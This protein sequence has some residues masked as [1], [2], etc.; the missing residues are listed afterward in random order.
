MKQPIELKKVSL[1]L[2]KDFALGPYPPVGFVHLWDAE[3]GNGDYYGL[4]WPLGKENEEPVVCDMLHDEWRLELSFSSLSKFI[5]W[6][7]ANNWER[8]DIEI[9]DSK[10]ASNLYERAKLLYSGSDVNLAINLL[11]E[12]CNNFPEIS[13]Y[14]FSLSSQYRRIGNHEEAAKAALKAFNSNWIFGFPNQGVLRTLKSM[15]SQTSIK[16][17]PLIQRIDEIDFDFGGTKENPVYSILD[18]C[19][20]EYFKKELYTDGL[21]MFQNY[22]YMMTSETISFQERNGFN[23]SEWQLKFSD[24]CLEYLGD[25]RLFEYK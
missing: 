15:R 18:G 19:I 16:D 2:S 9:K 5:E 7:D 4:Y 8:G 6:L 12:A 11:S 24:L 21:M 10:L 20:Q 22:A 13:E 3:L 1:P 14:W 25:N 23:L 17:D